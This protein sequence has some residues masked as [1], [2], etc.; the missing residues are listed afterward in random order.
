MS[1]GDIKE[2]MFRFKPGV[3]ET[4]NK[5]FDK[6]EVRCFKHIS[7]VCNLGTSS[8]VY[9]IAFRFCIFSLACAHT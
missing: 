6:L 1:P 3:E 7:H 5:A 9:M 2:A 8:S 4:I